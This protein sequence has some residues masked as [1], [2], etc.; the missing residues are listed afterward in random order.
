MTGR[1]RVLTVFIDEH[2]TGL[3]LP[4]FIMAAVAV[5]GEPATAAASRA[6]AELRRTDPMFDRESRRWEATQWEVFGRYLAEGTHNILPVSMHVRLD[7]RLKAS[8]T[9]SAGRTTFAEGDMRVV[10]PVQWLL[11]HS[12]YRTLA[13]VLPSSVLR[14]DG[15]DHVDIVIDRCDLRS[16]QQA[17]YARIVQEWTGDSCYR[18][19]RSSLSAA[20]VPSS[21]GI[22]Q[23][24]ERHAWGPPRLT[25][26]RGVEMLRVADAY[27][28]LVRHSLDGSE[29]AA[30]ALLHVRANC[31]VRGAADLA[32]FDVSDDATEEI[33]FLAA[34]THP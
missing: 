29:D 8:I 34:R 25:F 2:G 11:S 10:R 14:F 17:G 18:A 24:R 5:W 26:S 27:A 1:R 4:Y 16:D 6:F 31:L 19:S 20:R 9:D 32:T 12:L 23:E 33:R 3:D 28:S 15:I 22:R 7:E 30:A 21:L 13:L